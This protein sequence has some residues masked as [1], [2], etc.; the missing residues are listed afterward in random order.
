MSCPFAATAC[1]Y[2]KRRRLWANGVIRSNVRRRTAPQFL[3]QD[4]VAG[5]MI[6]H[7]AMGKTA[8]VESFKGLPQDLEQRLPVAIVF[9]NRL[10]SV[11]ACGRVVQRTGEFHSQRA[12]H[13]IRFRPPLGRTRHLTPLKYNAPSPTWLYLRTRFPSTP[14]QSR[15]FIL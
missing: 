3:S 14:I 10:A 11:T 9:E 4:G 1:A 15:I 12:G 2:F 8:G 13:G 5:Q 7:E 6:G